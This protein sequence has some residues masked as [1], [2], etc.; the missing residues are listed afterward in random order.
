MVTINDGNGGNT[1]NGTNDDDTINGNGGN[2]TINGLGGND[3][4]DG[5]DG[6]DVVN[7]GDGN[8]SLRGGRGTNTLTGGSGNDTYE[9]QV[10]GSAG[11]DFVDL[12]SGND[13]A[14]LGFFNAGLGPHAVNG[15]TGIDT[16]RLDGADINNS[17]LSLDL[18]EPGQPN[19]S[20]NFGTV[21]TNFENV[22][23]NA[24][25]NNLS[26]NSQNNVI[27][28][29]GGND[30]LSGEGGDDT[31]LGGTGN[32]TL[33]GDAG[34]DLLDGGDGADVLNGGDGNDTL[35]GGAGGDTL[36][37]G[38]GNDTI[39]ARDGADIVNG[40]AGDDSI[41]TSGADT[42]FGGA[43]AD[44]IKVEPTSAFL[45]ATV[46]ADGGFAGNDNDTLDLSALIADGYQVV[47]NLPVPEVLG[48]PGFSG[49]ITLRQPGLLGDTVIINYTDIENFNICFTA[50]ARITT[51]RGDI[52]VESVREGDRVL[53]RDN[54]FQ[55]VRWTGSTRIAADRLVFEDRMRPV[56]IRKDAFGEGCPARDTMVS[57]QHRM[58][59]AGPAAELYFDEPEV[60]VAA[61]DLTGLDGVHR[62]APAAGVL[63]VHLMFDRHEVVL[64]DGCWSESFQ[65][66]D[67][68]LSGIDQGQRS[69]IY[70]LFPELETPKGLGSYVAAR[71][72]LKT[73]EARLL[74]D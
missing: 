10:S 65:P 72:S 40:G 13:F 23:G 73:H 67:Y 21:Y 53:T 9:F 54:G 64:A 34:N 61:K 25:A 22:I 26:G 68:S 6:N 28:G 35:I 11:R 43:D 2:D 55:E 48:N 24:G 12:G 57:P 59:R 39:I 45:G 30:I 52:A 29:R 37:G 51:D 15:G 41:T 47:L 58:L 5:G 32:D 38:A 74:A 63:Y 62:V 66:G 31:L 50:G 49:T 44:T 4:L 36:N 18:G 14:F 42:I 8:D 71:R 16:I 19:E 7:G 33:N 1:L 56:L 20:Q 46:L 60:L 70:A 17:N 3:T 69:E 27:E